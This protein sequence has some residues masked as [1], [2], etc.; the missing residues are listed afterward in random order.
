MAE[1]YG[2][3]LFVG[4]NCVRPLQLPEFYADNQ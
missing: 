4:A 1:K 2:I 3:F